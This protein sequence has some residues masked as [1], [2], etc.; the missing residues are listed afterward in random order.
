[1]LKDYVPDSS[2][3]LAGLEIKRR[4]GRSETEEYLIIVS[5]ISSEHE[6]FF[7][8]DCRTTRAKRSRPREMMW[9]CRKLDSCAQELKN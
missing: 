9:L 7:P 2:E 5:M 3:K 6:E 4:G 8:N 1:M